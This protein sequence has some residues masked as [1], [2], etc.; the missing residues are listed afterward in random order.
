MKILI[1]DW[2]LLGSKA[3]NLAK[4]FFDRDHATLNKSP[5]CKVIGKTEP[6]TADIYYVFTED[7][8]IQFTINLPV[9]LFSVYASVHAT[10]CKI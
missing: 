7:S 6:T 9:C 1:P 5:H 3:I 8:F 10:K 4:M 2:E